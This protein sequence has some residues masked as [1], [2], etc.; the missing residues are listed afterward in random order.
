MLKKWGQVH[1]YGMVW[2]FSIESYK[3]RPNAFPLGNH[4]P[5]FPLFLAPK[6]GQNNNFHGLSM[7]PLF[8][9][10]PCSNH[11]NY[12]FGLKGEWEMGMHSVYIYKL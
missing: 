9:H 12:Y 10:L 4:W 7:S 3:Y 5:K 1:I 2:T 11:E 6:G 8:K